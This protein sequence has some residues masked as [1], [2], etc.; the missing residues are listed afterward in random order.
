MSV[1]ADREQRALS[2]KFQHL[3]LTKGLGGST[4]IFL[5]GRLY[6]L[7]QNIRPIEVSFEYLGS[8]LFNFSVVT[9]F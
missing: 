2:G 6:V 8:S 3:H 9:L 4:G 5:P 7:N 1:I